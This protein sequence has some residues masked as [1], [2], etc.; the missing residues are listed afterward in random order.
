MSTKSDKKVLAAYPVA[1]SATPALDQHRV[2]YGTVDTAAYLHVCKCARGKGQLILLKGIAGDIVKAERTD[3]VFAVTTINGKRYA[4]FMRNQTLVVD[5]EETKTLLSVAVLLKAG[6]I[7]KFVI[8][9]KRDPTFG[10]YLV[11]PDGQKIRM[12]FGDKLWRLPVSRWSDPV[13]YS[14][15]QTSPATTNTLALVPA[16]AALESLAQPSLPD[17]EAIQLVHDMWRHPDN[18]KM[19]QIYKSKRG[20]RFQRG[21]ITQLRKF[22]CATCVCR[23]ARDATAV[24][25]A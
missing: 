19:E 8:G 13:R 24:P 10:G 23:S 7:V 21:F 2:R 25:N 6:F 12:I 11:T 16:A 1:F 14:N 15:H 22:L 18:D 9:T 17:Q 20:R 4:I 5:K 3:V